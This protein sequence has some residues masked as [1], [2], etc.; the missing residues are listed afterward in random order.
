MTSINKSARI[1]GFLY[2]L[3][4]I[5]AAFVHFYV[6]AQLVVAG[7]ATATANQMM[8]SEGLF[9]ISMGSE[10]LLLLIEV[11]LTVLLYQLL[12]PV[13]QTLSLVAAASRLV[14]TTIHG[15]NIVNHFFVLLLL[16]GAGYLSVFE[17]N[18]L[19]ALV[20]LFLDAYGYG[21]T[22]GIVFF[23]LHTFPLGYLIYKSGYF[24][25]FLGLLFLVAAFLY[26]ID[27][28][29]LLLVGNYTTPVYVAIP[30]ALAEIAF[31]L[32]L[33]IKGV[34]VE[35]WKKRALVTA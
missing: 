19:H 20:M 33:L 5:V 9:R 18:Q 34:N 10:L 22:I 1:A 28:F 30:I 27:G 23:V 4:A 6:P 25:K 32:W 16:S 15:I 21:Y 29:S 3:I 35:E 13:N 7:D 26:L 2:F 12:K 31:P 17:P 8:A 24:P 14:M 11:V